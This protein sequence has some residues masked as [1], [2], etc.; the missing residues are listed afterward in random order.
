MTVP[1]EI[2]VPAEVRFGSLADIC[3]AKGHVRFASNSDRKS[4]HVPMVM[5]GAIE[6]TS[7]AVGKSGV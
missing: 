6:V 5:D 1:A 2:L 7:T 4:G 3:S